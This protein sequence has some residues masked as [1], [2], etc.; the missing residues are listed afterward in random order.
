MY[1]LDMI[2]YLFELKLCI[3]KS[4]YIQRFNTK[5]V[6]LTSK[7]VLDIFVVMITYG[8]AVIVMRICVV[9]DFTCRHIA[10]YTVLFSDG[11]WSWY[12]E[13]QSKMTRRLNLFR[14]MSNVFIRTE[15]HLDLNHYESIIFI[16][17]KTN[18]LW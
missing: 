8:T 4:L 12:V 16:M 1:N 18:F 2:T 11:R 13:N 17:I 7:F 5:Y 15:P 14:G 9:S 10:F 3:K 6:A